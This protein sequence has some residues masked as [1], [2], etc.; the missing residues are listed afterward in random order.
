VS[1]PELE[2]ARCKK[3]FASLKPLPQLLRFLMLPA[4][5]IIPVFNSSA[6]YCDECHRALITP[7]SLLVLIAIVVL[8]LTP[9]RYFGFI[10]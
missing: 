9:L 5:V 8:S 4:R 10:R 7:T 6:R 2:C 1:L 3:Q